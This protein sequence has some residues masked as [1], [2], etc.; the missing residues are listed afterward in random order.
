MGKRDLPTF[1]VFLCCKAD[2]L[3]I[4]YSRFWF[5]NLIEI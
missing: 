2:V 3:L 1:F 4:F 5:D